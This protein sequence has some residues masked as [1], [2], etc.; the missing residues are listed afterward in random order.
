[1]ELVLWKYAV[2]MFFQ[3]QLQKEART[4]SFVQN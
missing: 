2:M 1:M 3:T 4:M